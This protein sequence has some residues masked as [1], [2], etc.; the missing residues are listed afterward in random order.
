M[1]SILTVRFARFARQS[2]V[3]YASAQERTNRTRQNTADTS[4][5]DR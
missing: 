1:R 2:S 5:G 3:G 4:K